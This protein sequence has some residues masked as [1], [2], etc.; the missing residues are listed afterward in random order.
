[1]IDGDVAVPKVLVA[2]TV[3]V[4]EPVGVPDNTPVL[5]VKLSPAGRL[6]DATANVGDGEPDAANM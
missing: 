2:L 1:V 4:P 5:V 6:P 3:K